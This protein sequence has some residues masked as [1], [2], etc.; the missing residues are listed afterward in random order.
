MVKQAILQ[1]VDAVRKDEPSTRYEACQGSDEVSFMRFIS[2]G[3]EPVAGS[4]GARTR[5]ADRTSRGQSRGGRSARGTGRGSVPHSG[6]E[7]RSL[8]AI[9]VSGD[10]SL[11]AICPVCR[12]PAQVSSNL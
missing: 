8:S 11:R 3:D 1:F 7:A 4:P 10:L 5:A 9:A 2:F 12:V 6:I